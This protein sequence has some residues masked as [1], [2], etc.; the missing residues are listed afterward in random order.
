MHPILRVQMLGFCLVNN[1]TT[2]NSTLSP[3]I[4]DI[5]MFQVY[6]YIYICIVSPIRIGL[7][8]LPNG[9]C[10]ACKDL[11]I[12]PTETNPP[13]R[14][15]HLTPVRSNKPWSPLVRLGACHSYMALLTG[16]FSF[17]FLRDTGE[18]NTPGKP[19]HLGFGGIWTPKTHQHDFLSRYDWRTRVR[20][21][22]FFFLERK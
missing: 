4:E 11:V 22:G 21:A 5:H 3:N 17:F 13:S 2:P 7:F 18:V 20:M 14:G 12:L 6:I 10:M 15:T 8:P 19:K 9:L 1:T 16:N